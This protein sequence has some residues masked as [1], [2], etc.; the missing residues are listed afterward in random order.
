MT[1]E[2]RLKAKTVDDIIEAFDWYESQRIGLGGEFLEEVERYLDW[3][4]VNPELFRSLKHQ[5]VAFMKR[6]PFKIIFEIEPT[7]II[8]HAIYHNR[9]GPRGLSQRSH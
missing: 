5:R 1:R 6:F 8:V 7:A 4:V 3:I 2:L 9:R